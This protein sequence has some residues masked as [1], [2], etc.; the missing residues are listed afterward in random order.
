MKKNVVFWTGVQKE[1]FSEKY[2]GFEWMEISKKT[3]QFWCEKNNCIFFHYDS[4]KHDDFFQY[5]ITWQRW[6]D[7]FDK[8]EQSN[9]NYDKILMVDA[10]SMVKW[11]TPNIFDLVDDKLVGWRDMDNMK[12]IY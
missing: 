11:N 4:P 8:L 10:C 9:V 7:V 2:G 5:R 3:W 1:R 6:F 12:W